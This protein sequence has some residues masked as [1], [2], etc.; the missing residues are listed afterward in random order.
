MLIFDRQGRL[1][2]HYL[3]GVDDLRVGAEVMALLM[4]DKDSPREMSLVIERKLHM[5]LVDPNDPDHVHGEGCGHDHSHDHD[6]K[7]DHGAP[8][9]QPGHVH[10]PGCKH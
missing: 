8:H 2:R 6:H 3:G 7:H 4:E 10:G 9:G 5:A 1:R